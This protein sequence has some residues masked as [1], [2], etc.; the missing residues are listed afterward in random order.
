ML[1]DEL[2][3]NSGRIV[4]DVN[5]TQDVGVN[6]IA[7]QAIKFGNKV[8]KD[9][10]PYSTFLDYINFVESKKLDKKDKKK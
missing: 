5:T 9:G 2:Y 8:D 3:E 10:Y 6:E 7:K 1:L 4:K